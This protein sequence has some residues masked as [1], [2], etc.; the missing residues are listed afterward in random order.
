MLRTWV[1][2][3]EGADF[4][5]V[6]IDETTNEIVIPNGTMGERH[7]NPQKWNLRLENRDTGAKI[8]PRLSVFDQ[9]EDVTVVKLPYFGDEEHEGVIERAI[10]TI[11]VQTVDGPVK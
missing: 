1:A 9:R 6:L 4:Q 2:K 3:E 11:T 7:T 10:P 5:M 8:D